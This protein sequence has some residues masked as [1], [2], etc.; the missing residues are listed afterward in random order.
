MK[1]YILFLHGKYNQ[2]EISYFNTLIK[3]KISIAVDGGLQFFI[4]SKNRP[5]LILG[6]F[7][8]I[9]EKSLKQ[10]SEIEIVK[11]PINKNKSDSQLAVEFCLKQKAKSITIVMPSVGEIDHFLGN[12]MLPGLYK[13]RQ[14]I[15]AGGQFQICSHDYEYFYLSDSKKI[16]KNLVGHTLSIIPLS[17]KIEISIQGFKYKAVNLIV[18]KGESH[19]LRNV[20]TAKKAVLRIDGDA[21]VV[22]KCHQDK[23]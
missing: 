3:N 13:I 21:V 22:C 7:D 8:S 18:K 9:S 16:F 23:R 15:K 1:N 12:M 19:A 10:F 11:Y 20:I 5:D 4:K 14:W 6:D 2:N 17:T